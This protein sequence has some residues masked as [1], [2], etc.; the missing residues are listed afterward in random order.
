VDDLIHREHVRDGQFAIHLLDDL[1]DGKCEALEIARRADDEGGA[2]KCAG[3]D[4][5]IHRRLRWLGQ[6]VSGVTHDADD[7]VTPPGEADQV[8]AD[9]VLIWKILPREL[10][11]DDGFVG[12]I[13][14]LIGTEGAAAEKWDF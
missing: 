13:K 2:A 3:V 8:L 7:V 6:L 5:E 10:S 12:A 14:T 4:R 11:A 9:R 1:L